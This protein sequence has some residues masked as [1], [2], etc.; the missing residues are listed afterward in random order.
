[1]ADDAPTCQVCGEPMQPGEEMFMYHGSLGPCPK[2][3]RVKTEEEVQIAA[4]ARVQVVYDSMTK[5]QFAKAMA[6]LGIGT[7]YE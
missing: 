6:A 2:P 5:D 7:R 3:P 1:M 4:T